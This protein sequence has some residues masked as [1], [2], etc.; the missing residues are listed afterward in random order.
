MAQP[1]TID[2]LSYPPPPGATEHISEYLDHHLN[3]LV[4]STE[5]YVKDTNHFLSMLAGLGEIPGDALL[6]TVDVV[7]LYPSIPHDEGLEAMRHALSSRQNPGV[8][9]GSLVNL[10]RVVLGSNVF[11]FDGKVYNQKLGTAIW[12]KFAFANLFMADLEKKMLYGCADKPL[13]WLRYIGDVFFIW[14]HGRRKL[15]SFLEY[16]NSFH[17]TIKFT[18][19]SSREGVSFLDVMME[20]KGRALE[21]DLYCKP[22]ADPAHS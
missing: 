9:T 14:T 11:G 21:T 16:I 2:K 20:R 4:S 22:G 1:R 15:N 12:T 5:S 7:G 19:E 18:S 6:C 17:E 8:S 13:V 3:P 10:A